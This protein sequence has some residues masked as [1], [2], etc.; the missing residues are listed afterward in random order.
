MK[1]FGL[2]LALALLCSCSGLR[3][4]RV[5]EV[6]NVQVKSFSGSTLS[7]GLEAKINNP[8]RRKLQLTKLELNVLRGSSNFATISATEKVKI[9]KRS[10]DFSSVPLE[11]K[12]NNIL[13]AVMMLQ[14]K[15]FPIDEL[16]VEGEI[17]AKIFPLSKKIRIEKMSLREFSLQY[18]DMITPL[19]NTRGK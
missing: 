14:Q 8:S 10:N 2:L 16:L 9:P 12:L 19:L 6:R 5:E 4:I 18:G 1:N 7:V 3:Q 11:V 17:K 15:N 13:S